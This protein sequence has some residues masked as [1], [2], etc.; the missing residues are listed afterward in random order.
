MT[1]QEKRPN[2]FHDVAEASAGDGGPG[3]SDVVIV[4]APGS[5]KS[6]VGALLAERLGVS[7]VDVDDVIE[8]EAGK[9]IAEIFAEDGEGA[10]RAI[11]EATTRR[12]LGEPGV[13]S[14]GGGAVL[15][16]A[17]RKALRGQRVI[18]LQVG[19]PAAMKRVGLA[20]ARPLLL[21]NVRGRL[22]ALLN[23]RVPLYTEV[24][25]EVV[26]TDDLSPAEV[27]DAIMASIGA[28]EAP[29]AV[30]RMAA[31]GGETGTTAVHD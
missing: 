29:G 30:G 25:T 10:F 8:A 27:V 1:T 20:T 6:T 18:W 28:Y 31:R 4:G 2:A 22:I 24:A 7:F 15:S 17:T 21:G 14:L 13:L 5:G 23:E 12:L 3:M 16:G 19:V 26:D 11:E 9:T